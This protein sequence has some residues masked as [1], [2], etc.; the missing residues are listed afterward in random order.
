MKIEMKFEFHEL[1]NF[2]KTLVRTSRNKYLKRILYKERDTLVTEAERITPV[3][4]G[5][6]KKHWQSDNRLA[7]ARRVKDGYSIT[8]RN[9]AKNKHGFEYANCVDQGHPSYNQFGG[10]YVVHNS[11]Y[12]RNGGPVIGRFIVERA[13]KKSE[14]EIKPEVQHQLQRWLDRCV[15][16]AK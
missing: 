3:I 16:N 15:K 10:P 6:M 9:K 11:K 4:T 13:H 5:T 8:I 14:R 7:R 12:H 1:E 2:G